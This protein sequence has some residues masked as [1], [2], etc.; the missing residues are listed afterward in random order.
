MWQYLLE[1]GYGGMFRWDGNETY[2]YWDFN[3]QRWIEDGYAFGV[4]LGLE[5]GHFCEASEDEAIKKI[6]LMCTEAAKR[7]VTA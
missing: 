7:Q 6:K 5:S 2:Q 1:A 3:K 4:F